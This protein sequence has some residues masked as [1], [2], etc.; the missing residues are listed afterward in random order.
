VRIL[1]LDTATENC[2]AALFINGA[3]FERER[4]LERG[5]AELILPMIRELLDEAAIVLKD[6]TA[7]AFGRGPGGF[8]GVRLAASVTQGLA[9]GAGVPVVPVS[10]LRALA[11]RALREDPA[12]ARVLC[13]TDARMHQVYCG[14]F[15]RSPEGA[16]AVGEETVRGPGQVMLPSAWDEGPKPVGV[17][18]GFRAYPEL[19]LGLKD[20][21]GVARPDLWPRARE[22]ALL[23]VAEVE[24]GRA[25]PADAAIPV[26][27]RDDVA[28]PPRASH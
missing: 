14:A 7:I 23:A 24:G 6:L 15:E 21:L 9:F 2:S 10:N 4:L 22:M 16:Q 20:R 5:H 18:S 28:Q 17:G 19:E 12:A 13:C 1:A 3:L 25:V 11:E 26:Y 8:T 27:V